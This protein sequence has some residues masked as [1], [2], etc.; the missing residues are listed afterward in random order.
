MPHSIFI[1]ERKGEGGRAPELIA[2]DID[3][4]ALANRLVRSIAKSNRDN[5]F[6]PESH[7]RWFKVK[8]STFYVYRLEV[9]YRHADAQK[10]A[11]ASYS[12]D[13]ETAKNREEAGTLSPTDD[14]RTGR[15]R[16]SALSPSCDLSVSRSLRNVS[17][18]LEP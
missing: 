13:G 11:R 6:D 5:G 4:V 1:R 12:I 16:Q 18:R 17:V 9:E 2:Y 10:A 14:V 8:D 7:Q 15:T 3:S